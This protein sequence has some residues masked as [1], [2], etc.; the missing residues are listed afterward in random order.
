MS[1]ATTCSAGRPSRQLR[2]RRRWTASSILSASLPGGTATNYNQ[3]DTGTHEVGHWLGLYHT[4]QGGCY[5]SGD[6]VDDTPAEASAGLRVPDRP[7]H[8][9]RPRLGPDHE[10]HGLHLRLVHDDLH[11]LAGAPHGGRTWTAY[12]AGLTAVRHRLS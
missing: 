4:F 1:S 6:D 10:L 7:G 9:R 2:Q 3:G 12:R 5:G 8:L 11:R